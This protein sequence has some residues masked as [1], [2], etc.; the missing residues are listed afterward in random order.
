MND[1]GEIVYGSVTDEAKE[2]LSYINSLYNQGVIDND[3]LLRTSTNI[4]E[5]IENGLCG[6]FFG[7]LWAPNNP[8]ANA[9]S[10]NPDRLATIF[11]SNGFG[12]DNELS[13]P[14]PVLQICCCK[15]GL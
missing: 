5:L 11:N 7:P 14:E 8:L 2:A 13:Q 1:D 15:K 4:C 9:V 6:S 3:F 12:W 10:R